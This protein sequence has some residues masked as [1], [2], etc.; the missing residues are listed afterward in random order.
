ML[1]LATKSYGYRYL[2]QASPVD[3][4][5]WDTQCWTSW[6]SILCPVSCRN[7]TW[8][9][10]PFWTHREHLS[11]KVTHWCYRSTLWSGRSI[12]H[13]SQTNQTYASKSH[14]AHLLAAALRS[15]VEGCRDWSYQSSLENPQQC[16][17]SGHFDLHQHL[18]EISSLYLKIGVFLMPYFEHLYSPES[19]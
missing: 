6:S 18:E 8:G 11:S 3:S 14:F 1:S 9:L 4:S 5:V 10:A 19:S 16:L 15:W 7:Y 17:S 2:K 12:C 13:Q